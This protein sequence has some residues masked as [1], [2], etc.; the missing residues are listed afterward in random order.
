M[1]KRVQNVSVSKH[2]AG[3][4]TLD[5]ELRPLTTDV[6]VTLIVSDLILVSAVTA[7]TRVDSDTILAA[8]RDIIL[9]DDIAI[10]LDGDAAAVDCTGHGV[11]DDN[12]VTTRLPSTDVVWVVVLDV[13]SVSMGVLNDIVPVT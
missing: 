1:A 3:A 12:M 2:C 6:P 10:T 4:A 13:N 8:L 11:P 7:I 9:T 5:T